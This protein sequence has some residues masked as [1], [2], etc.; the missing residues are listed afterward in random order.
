MNIQT[1]E[2]KCNLTSTVVNCHSD[3][4]SFSTKSNA[5]CNITAVQLC[6]TPAFLFGFV[7]V[8]WKR[9]TK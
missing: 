5:W 9:G 8:W 4:F 7:I 2:G 1:V 3:H 6:S